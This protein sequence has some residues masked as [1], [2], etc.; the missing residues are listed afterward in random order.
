MR[1]A[2]LVIVLLVSGITYADTWATHVTMQTQEYKFG[3]TRIVVEYGG[4]QPGYGLFEYH[5]IK[6]YL[7]EELMALYRNVG[8]K[9]IYASEDNQFFVGVS[10]SGIPGTAFIVFDN[11]GNLIREV[12]HGYLGNDLYTMMSVTIIREWYN[13]DKP[14]IKF[15][16]QNNRLHDIEINGSNGLRYKL[17][18]PHLGLDPEQANTLLRERRRAQMEARR[19]AK[20]EK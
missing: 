19:K 15:D 9:E 6:I 3:Q 13:K 11:K 14:E 17:L 5:A 7:N 12:K 10:N 18:R 2:I 8:F 16:I 4:Q 1:V 20:E